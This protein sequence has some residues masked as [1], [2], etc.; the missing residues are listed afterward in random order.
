MLHKKLIPLTRIGK[1]F[2]YSSIEFILNS[3]LLL[4]GRPMDP[5][6]T[7][8]PTLIETVKFRSVRAKIAA[9]SRHLMMELHG[10][11]GI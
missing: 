1:L 4:I 5:M 7:K 6:L 2:K 9:S 11:L 10:Y 3:I 8:T